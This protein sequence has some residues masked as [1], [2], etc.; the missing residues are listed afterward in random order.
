MPK[1]HFSKENMPQSSEEF[2]QILREAWEKF[3]PIDDFVEVI[4]ELTLLEQRYGMTSQDFYAKFQSGELEDESDFFHWATQ[5]E[6]YLEIKE[7]LEKT[8]ELLQ[9]YA[10][11][12]PTWKETSAAT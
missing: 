2:R 9:Y 7:T 1:L 3:N 5:Y 11:P 8:F 4:R 6:I 10:I 12:I